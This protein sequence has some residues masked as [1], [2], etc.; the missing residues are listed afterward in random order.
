MAPAWRLR[1]VK[2]VLVYN[3]TGRVILE[4][5]LLLTF[6][7][8]KW[9]SFGVDANRNFFF[10]DCTLYMDMAK[11]HEPYYPVLSKILLFKSP[12]VIKSHISFSSSRSQSPMSST[13]ELISGSVFNYRSYFYLMPGLE[14]PFAP[15]L[16]RWNAHTSLVIS[17]SHLH[18]P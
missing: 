12:R 13:A 9:T 2:S 11:Q 4:L 6:K 1:Q 5:L 8:H 17:S 16:S 18:V 10:V 7:I 15:S 3:I 14:H